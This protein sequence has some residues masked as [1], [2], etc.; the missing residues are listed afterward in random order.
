M[1]DHVAMEIYILMSSKGSDADFFLV[2]MIIHVL[3]RINVCEETPL[4]FKIYI[5]YI[6]SDNPYFLCILNSGQPTLNSIKE[7]KFLI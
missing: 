2:K 3:K 5:I 6:Q 1:N 4:K 7:Y